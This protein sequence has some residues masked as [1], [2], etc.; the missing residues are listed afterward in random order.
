[1]ILLG[2]YFQRHIEK[3]RVT[4]IK[5]V[6]TTSGSS[7]NHFLVSYSSGCMYVYNHELPCAPTTHA[8]VYQLFKQGQG[9]AVYTCKTK[10]T[11]NPLYKWAVGEAVGGNLSSSSNANSQASFAGSSSINEFAFSPCG[12]YLAVASQVAIWLLLVLVPPITLSSIQLL[13]A[14]WLFASV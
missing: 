14:G 2:Y 7:S 3:T 9:Y 4:C 1:M 5:W 6:P 10:T 12:H 11:R 8:P 13:L